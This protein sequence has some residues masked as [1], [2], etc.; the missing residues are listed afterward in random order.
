MIEFTLASTVC[1][2]HEQ[3]RNLAAAL[4]I[5]AQYSL[6][7]G[8]IDRHAECTCTWVPLTRK[9][10]IHAGDPPDLLLYGVIL[11]PECLAWARKEPPPNCVVLDPHTS[12]QT[13]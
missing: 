13:N 12:H 2:G 5:N 11:F 1:D 4:H 6:L 9:Q 3:H 8:A 7:L 10:V